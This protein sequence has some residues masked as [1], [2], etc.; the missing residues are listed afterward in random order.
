MKR[1][2]IFLTHPAVDLDFFFG[3]AALQRLSG[4]CEVILNRLNRPLDDGEIIEF[5]RDCD[6]IV[7]E[8]LTGAGTEVFEQISSL[9]AFVR[10]GV[11]LLNVDLES[12]TET[13]VL[14]VSTPA[15]FVTSVAEF[16]FGAM[17]ALAR[18]IVAK[19]MSVV[20]GE[21]P[22]AYCYGVS[23]ARYP[24]VYP[25]FELRGETIGL[26][27]L[28]A[29]GREVARLARAFGMRVIA[30]DPYVLSAPKDVTLLSIEAV[31]EQARI[32]SLHAVL[33]S[34]THHLIGEREFSLMRGDAL[35]IN[36]ARGGLVDAVALRNALEA[37]QIAGTAIDAHEDEPDFSRSPLLGCAN[38]VLTPHIA[39]ITRETM[40]RQA[41]RCVDIVDEILAGGA[42][43]SIV[44]PAVLKRNNLRLRDTT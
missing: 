29:I 2:R 13:G 41:A 14:V 1:Q 18:D 3:E 4:S 42:P 44:N 34:E 11:E 31:L 25:G 16:T 23:K 40:E 35:L 28:G 19:H 24:A 33:T 6:V 30:S 37:G 43:A 39:G 7:S 15:Q 32:V 17:L 8:W 38:A 36:T 10:C 9:K 27:G 22:L 26:I 12:A 5:A 21:I 20:G